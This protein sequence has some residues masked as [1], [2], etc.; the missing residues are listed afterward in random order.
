MERGPANIS[1][2]Q[3]AKVF[4]AK[5]YIFTSSQKFSPAKVSSYI[6]YMVRYFV[7]LT[8]HCTGSDSVGGGERG[9]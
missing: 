8:D 3:S 1:K 7:T 4:S 9:R 2:G 6:L 5:R